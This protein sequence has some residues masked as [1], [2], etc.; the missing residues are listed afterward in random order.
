M[1]K[2]LIVAYH[3][4]LGM[5][6]SRTSLMLTLFLPLLLIFI[7][8]SALSPMFGDGPRTVGKV[9]LAV[10]PAD[11]GPLSEQA[12]QLL[13]SDSIA[14]ILTV[15][16]VASVDEVMTLLKQEEADFGIEIPTTFS[17]DASA[18]KPAAWI[19]YS[20]ISVNKNLKAEMTLRYV[21]DRWN[22]SR[23]MAAMGIMPSGAQS[24]VASEPGTEHKS[25]VQEQQLV[26][27]GSLN[28][29]HAVTSAMEYYSISMLIMFLMMTG[30]SAGVSLSV[31]RENHTLERLYAMPVRTSFI[32]FG[33]L[34][35]RGLFAAFQAL[36]IVVFTSSVYGVHWGSSYGYLALTCVLTI[37]ASLSFALFLALFIR[38]T[39]NVDLIFTLSVTLMT[40]ISGGMA[41]NLG[42]LMNKIAQ[43]TI[44]RW[45]MGSLTRIMLGLGQ[46]AILEQ[47]SILALIS[48]GLFLA[49]IIGYRKAGYYA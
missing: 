10:Y 31:E 9:T 11:K 36:I 14:D 16:R 15:L 23:A 28:E 18:G 13:A 20:G 35:G 29:K 34:A 42:S 30:V 4:I 3:E 24:A 1:M 25:S 40:F 43:F 27:I 44:N 6:R 33:K 38:T 41:P 12:L 39:R 49:A 22:N 21:L 46:T 37:V 47:L 5:L 48:L 45:A 2:L 19:L 8:G 17:A 32:I 7:L 26:K